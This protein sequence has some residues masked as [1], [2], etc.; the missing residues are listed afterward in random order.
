MQE[1]IADL[2]ANDP[3]RFVTVMEEDGFQIWQD[4]EFEG[5]YCMKKGQQG[6]EDTWYQVAYV[7]AMQ[8]Q[9]WDDWAFA[10]AEDEDA[11]TD[12]IAFCQFSGEVTWGEEIWL[13]WFE[14]VCKL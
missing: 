12:T 9:A 3:Q 6:E 10:S 1:S 11:F 14:I 8:K 2:I 4:T 5:F 7:A 13:A